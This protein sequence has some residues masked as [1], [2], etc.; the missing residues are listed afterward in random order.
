MVLDPRLPR[1]YGWAWGQ[2]CSQLKTWLGLED[3]HRRWHTSLK[4][5]RQED[6]VLL[7]MELSTRQLPQWWARER[8]L[9][10]EATGFLYSQLKSGLPSLLP[11]TINY[12]S[13]GPT[14]VHCGKGLHLGEYRD[15]GLIDGHFEGWQLHGYHGLPRWSS[16]LP[17][18]MQHCQEHPWPCFLTHMHFSPGPRSRIA[19]IPSFSK[20]KLKLEKSDFSKVT[21]LIACKPQITT[22]A[23][24][25]PVHSISRA[26]LQAR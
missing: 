11:R 14:L 24:W 26:I 18:H 9:K 6:S 16:S 13:C 10:M 8:E 7:H 19:A 4:G 17:G 12:G 20:G 21:L 23:T 3:G 22:S 1:G 2:G 15:A 25:L 5:C